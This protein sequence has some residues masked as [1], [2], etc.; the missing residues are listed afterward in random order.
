MNGLSTASVSPLVGDGSSASARSDIERST[1]RSVGWRLL[2]LLMASY[3]IA[4]V[5]RVNIGIAALDM[6]EIG[7]SDAAFGLGGTMFFIAYA[8]F[9]IP[10]NL[11]LQRIGARVWIARIM[12][13]WGV[14]G[15]A[16][17][18]VSGPGSFYF[19]RFLLGAAEAGFFPGVILY[20]TYWFP[21]AYRARII[22]TF[23]VAIP[24]SNFLGSP[25][26]TLLLELD[27]LAGLRGWQWV[28]IGESL[29]AIV[30]G[31]LV[32][33]F[34]TSTPA[35]A[36]WL[37]GPQ[38]AWL[39][40]ELAREQTQAASAAP[41]SNWAIVRDKQVW[42]LA[43]IY[44]GSSATSNALSLWQP[45]IL[46]SFELSNL[47]TGFLN[48]IPFGLAAIFMVLWGRYA[49]ATRERRWS[50]AL[51][52]ALTSASLV[53][54]I[55]THSLSI[56]LALLSLALIGNYAIKGPYWALVTETL[57]PSIVGASIAAINTLAHVGT[58]GTSALI[59]IIKD[60]TGSY[61]LALLPLATLTALG[62][63]VVL[64]I[65]RPQQSEQP[66]AN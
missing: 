5:D 53:L 22:A 55:T 38:R 47:E 13:S 9:E 29:P 15:L 46:K 33:L 11:A 63:G 28:F 18:L 64:W 51:P 41:R 24:V 4:Y 58:G 40:Q 26:S 30:L 43:L 19:T 44:C 34:L 39:Q 31:L 56:T 61:P 17:C 21:P 60:A 20:L 32:M 14:V 16:T 10:S 57:P 2:P 49:D 65:G 62:A 6:K 1:M 59:G 7:L 45:K 54:T 23:M 50:T 48:M 42:L 35:E 8:L 3:F 52:L 66:P 25:L 37:S 12:I 27:G 36:K